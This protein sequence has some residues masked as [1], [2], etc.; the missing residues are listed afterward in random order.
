MKRLTVLATLL[1]FG[2]SQ[3]PGC[4]LQDQAATM[5]TSV[6]VKELECSNVE[7]VRAD[8]LELVSKAGLCKN[9]APTGPIADAICPSLTAQLIEY[10]ASTAIPA[11]WGCKPNSATSRLSTLILEACK[12]IPVVEPIR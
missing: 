3:N 9:P 12:K 2:C 4:F 6:I 10:L 1:M 5:A 8:M 11:E 7:V